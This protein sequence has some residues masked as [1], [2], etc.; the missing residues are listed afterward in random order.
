[1]NG[2]ARGDGRSCSGLQRDCSPSGWPAASTG[3]GCAAG[4]MWRS[5]PSCGGRTSSVP[6]VTLAISRVPHNCR[7]AMFSNWI[8]ID[9]PTWPMKRI[10]VTGAAKG[11]GRATVDRL[12]SDGYAVLAVDIDEAGLEELRSGRGDE[13]EIFRCDVSQGAEVKALFARLE[14]SPPYGLVNNAGIYLGKG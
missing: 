1:M 12:L 14:D 2:H 6:C 3:A 9:E 11:I 5:G 8:E 7:A 4:A 10:L 13:L